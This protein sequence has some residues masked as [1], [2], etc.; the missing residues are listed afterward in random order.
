[1]SRGFV[2]VELEAAWEYLDRYI[3]ANRRLDD[4]GDGW[5]STIERLR[6]VRNS[7]EEAD[8]VIDRNTPKVPAP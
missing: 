8:M 7:I 5:R 1:M 6:D 3:Q 2:S 4:R